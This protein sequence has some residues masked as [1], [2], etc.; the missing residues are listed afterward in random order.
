MAKTKRIRPSANPARAVWLGSALTV[1]TALAAGCSGGGDGESSPKGLFPFKSMEAAANAPAAFTQPRGGVPLPDGSVALL[2]TLEGQPETQTTLAG[3]RV[4]VLLQPPGG[5]MPTVLYAG[6]AIVNPFDID[7]SLDGKTLYVADPAAG[8]ESEGAILELAVGGGTAPTELASGYH[9]RSVTV[10]SDGTMFFSGID[11]T[12]GDPGV[13]HLANG[14]TTAVFTGAPFVDP[15]GIALMKDGTVLVVDTCLFDAHAGNMPVIGS[16]A[17][18]VRVKNGAA[19]IFATGFA[20]GYP[21]GIALSID[22][23][24]LIVSAEGADRSDA[25][26]VFDVG[27]PAAEPLI[28]RDEFSRF[29]D[30]SAGLKR[31]HDSN[32]F[33]WASL[34][35]NGGT[36]YKIHGN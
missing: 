9:P 16:E 31:A 27:N 4:A 36:V 7:V 10:A 34:S 3:E 14:M 22:E 12:S 17:G 23:A 30:S 5:G 28:V 35:A 15:S 6:D 29:Q 24:S 25:L 32:T 18:I 2:A 20:T 1:V 13:F 21:A 19:G 8:R 33:I 11:P 26:Y